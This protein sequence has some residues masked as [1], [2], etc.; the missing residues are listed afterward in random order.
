[1]KIKSQKLKSKTT[2]QSAK[3]IFAISAERFNARSG[4]PTMSR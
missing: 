2:M 1:M 4:I 3:M